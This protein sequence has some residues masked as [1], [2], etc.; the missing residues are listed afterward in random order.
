VTELERQ[1]LVET[2]RH[3]A[4]CEAYIAKQRDLIERAIQQGRSTEVA[5]ET[6]E[7]LEAGL[8][9]LE[10]Q[11]QR[12]LDRLKE[13]EPMTTTGKNRIMI[14]G[15]KTDGTYVVEFRTAE[16]RRSRSKGVTSRVLGPIIENMS[17][18]RQL[19]QF[20][21]KGIAETL[22]RDSRHYVVPIWWGTNPYDA[23]TVLHAASCFFVEIGGTRFGITA[24]HVIAEYL[25]DREKHPGGFLMIR[26]TLIGDW[27]SRFIDGS[28]RWDV[29]TFRVSDAEF[30]DINIRALVS[31]PE[32]WPPP[33]P[34]VGRGV[35]FTGYPGVDRKVMGKKIVE[36]VQS[37]N[38]V[39]VRA[40]SEDDVELTID[41]AFLKS[42]NGN[43]IP[44]TTKNLGGYSG[45]P[46]LVVSEKPLSSLFWLGGVVIRQLPAKDEK[47]MTTVWARR[48]NCIRPDGTL[49][50]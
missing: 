49:V 21:A 32:T 38:S 3:I 44:P 20:A 30:R 33:R 27:D 26:N 31:T 41:P 46:L 14:F 50:A 7:A 10:R 23:S 12:L 22:H 37:S 43:P 48:P 9:A 16:G 17:A 36:F 25:A 24:F 40:L 45:S 18:I 42:L 47:D 15:P 39:V 29:A 5:E 13:R 6:L 34:Q 1:H 35:I 28:S 8:R 4:E 2:D 11:R 19:D